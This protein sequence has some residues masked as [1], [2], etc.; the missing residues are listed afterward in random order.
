MN[1]PAIR[2][3]PWAKLITLIVPKT[4]FSPSAMSAYTPP[5]SRPLTVACPRLRMPVRPRGPPHPTLSPSA[6]ERERSD[7][8]EGWVSRGRLPRGPEI[9]PHEL[10]VGLGDVL[11][12]EDAELAA[13]RLDHHRRRELV[14]A[15]LVELDRL[16][17]QQHRPVV[18]V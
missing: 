8:R 15:R 4:M 6:G 11:R 12:V 17:R 5:I 7:P 10:G 18:D 13:L 9:R 2:S 16:V 3:A 1:I 14:L